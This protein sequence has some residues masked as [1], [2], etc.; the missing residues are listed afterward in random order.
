MRSEF[1]STESE[2][3]PQRRAFN[4]PLKVS[5]NHSAKHCGPLKARLMTTAKSQIFLLFF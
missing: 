5:L 2:A 3:L 1:W 4:G